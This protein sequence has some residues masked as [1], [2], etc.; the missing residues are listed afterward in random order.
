MIKK[1]FLFPGQGSQYV[2]MGKALWEQFKVAADVFEQASDA[3]GEDV[4]KLCFDSPL[5]ELTLTQNAQPAILTVSK[6]MYEVFLQEVGVTPEI[7]AGHSLGEISALT[8]A[9]A[10]DFSDAVKIARKR[11]QFMQQVVEPGKGLMAAVQTRDVAK[12]DEICTEASTEDSIVSISNYNTGVQTVISGDKKAVETAM[13]MIEKEGMK[14]TLLNVS[15]PFHC[16]LMKPAAEMLGEELKKYTFHDPSCI[17]LSNV[18]AT[19]YEGKDSIVENLTK[20]LLMPVQ[21]V[22]SMKYMKR[23]MIRYGVELGPKDVLKKMMKKNIAD[24]PVIAYDD[25]KDAER[26]KRYIDS[27]YIPFL[28]RSM[29]IAVATKN[30]NWNTQDYEKGVVEPYQKIQRIQQQIEEEN[31]TATEEEM[32]EAIQMLLSVFKT[33]QISEQEQTKR[34]AQLFNET[35]TQKLFA[36]FKVPTIS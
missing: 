16:P 17:V 9:G 34:F 28:T 22:D 23:S 35:G 24:I 32:K 27:L 19:P 31:R 4:R 8:C 6:A 7:M 29:G 5:E 36:D 3:L 10:I 2:G 25:T 13:E 20:Q 30:N 18:T 11:G 21:W 26:A 1:A 15:A 33:K 14:A 12:L